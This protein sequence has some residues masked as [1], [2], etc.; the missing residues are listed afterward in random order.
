MNN[1]LQ[2]FSYALRSLR[3]SPT[4]ALT[5]TLTLALGVGANTAIFSVTNSVLLRPHRFPELDR[6]V[7]LREH[8]TG[9]ANEQVRLAVGDAVDLADRGDIF[10]EL[11][12]YQFRDLNLSQSGEVDTAT[13]FLVTPNLFHLLG[14]GPEHGHTFTAAEGQPGRDQVIL[15]SHS[16]WERRFGGDPAVIGSTISVDGTNSTVMGVMPRDFNYPP[17]AEVWKPLAMTREALSDRSKESVG[18]VARLAPGVSLREASARLGSVAA[19]LQRDFPRTNIGRS[20]SSLRLR[21]EQWADTAPLLLMLQSGASFVLLLA[22]ANLGV[23]TLVRLIDRRREFAVRTAL[24]ASKR[25][26][27]QMFFAEALLFSLAGGAAAVSAS[28]WGVNLI[29]ASL[30][31]SYTRWV[32]GWDSMR[33]DEN[34][35]IAAVAL[36]IAVAMALGI[37]A[38]VHSARIDPSTTMKEGGRTGISRRHHALRNGLVVVQITLALI[39]LVGAGLMMNGFRRLQGVFAVLDP[40]HTLRFEISLPES[41]YASARISQFYDRLLAQLASIPGLNEAGIITNNPASNVPNPETQ[42]TIEGREV[43]RLSET[44]VTGRQIVNSGAFSVVHIPLIDGRR[45]ADN[46]GSTSPRVAVVSHGLADRYF[47]G[48]SAVGHRIRFTS[49]TPWITIVGV[50]GD[51]QI[52]WFEPVPGPVV[53]LPYSQASPRRV[54]FLVR[55]DGDASRYRSAVRA[56]ISDL[57][58]LLSSGELNPYTVEVSDS[59]APL[60]AIGDLML[61]FGVVAVVLAAIGIYGLIGQTVAQGTHEFGVRMAL[62]AERNDVLRLVLKRALRLAGVG[63]GLGCVFAIALARAARALVFG[64]I[65]L[66]ASV[67]LAFSALLLAVTLLAAFLPARRASRVDPMVALREQ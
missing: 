26:L 31:P 40:A 65:S 19:R 63:L 2:D 3:K 44:P 30:S 17:G 59:L 43:T 23:L 15:L 64:V 20:F 10:Q 49:D 51:I 14:I 11:A 22:C 62:G 56:A 45:I 35:L 21:Q 66:H 34:V 25:R 47:H 52:N 29:R 9:R 38:V 4:F 67:F 12:M 8:V 60:R 46:D 18:V 24:G 13:G 53:Y 6:L 42:F 57:D 55:T 37:A 32:A 27:L 58:P 54:T 48:G 16:F 33:V 61:A 28:F 1:V 41:R 36:V 50:V 39:L 5:A 7:V